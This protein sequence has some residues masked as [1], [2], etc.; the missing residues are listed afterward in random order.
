M[1]KK[2]VAGDRVRARHLYESGFEFRATGKHLY[3][4]NQVPDVS[5]NVDDDDDAFWRRWLLVE[6]PNYYPPAERDP[7]LPETLTEPTT[8][9]A[10][11]NW[12]VEGRARLLERGRFTGEKEYP[13]EKRERWQAWG[14]SVD[15]FVSECVERDEDAD[16]LTTADAHQRYVA[17][18]RENDLK[19]VGQ[20]QF[21]NRLKKEGV[22]YKTGVR[23]DGRSQR[24]YKALGFTDD[25]PEL[26]DDHDRDREQSRLGS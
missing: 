19:D 24:G 9:S 22:G 4:A 25:V 12:A 17:W 15:K 26:N 10:V 21:T 5:D 18:C 20:Q 16:R 3:A 1:F 2:L 8:L 23:I 14:D 7:D 6:F 13:Q 11:L